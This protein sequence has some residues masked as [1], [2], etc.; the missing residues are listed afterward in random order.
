[1]HDIFVVQNI[2]FNPRSLKPVLTLKES[3]M[4]HRSV[5]VTTLLGKIARDVLADSESIR[6]KI[7]VI[8]GYN[9]NQ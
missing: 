6:A 8:V 5:G 2:R 3:A 1:M 7:S 4:A 9:L